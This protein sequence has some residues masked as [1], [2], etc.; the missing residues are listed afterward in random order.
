MDALYPFIE[1]GPR[2]RL[3][4]LPCGLAMKVLNKLWDRLAFIFAAHTD[5]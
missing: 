1:T 4:F 2:V 3:L 5:I